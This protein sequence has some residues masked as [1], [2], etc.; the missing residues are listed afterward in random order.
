M[1]CLYRSKVH[2]CKHGV[3]QEEYRIEQNSGRGKL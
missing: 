2:L 3:L 1:D